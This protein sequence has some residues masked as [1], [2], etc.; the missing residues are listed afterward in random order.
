MLC[1]DALSSFEPVVITK[2]KYSGEY[3]RP[4]HAKYAFKIK[5]NDNVEK[6]TILIEA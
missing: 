5:N 2:F 6:I 3:R 1:P 4:E